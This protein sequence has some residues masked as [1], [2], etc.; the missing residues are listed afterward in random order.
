MLACSAA[1]FSGRARA[2]ACCAGAGAVT[3]GRLAIHEDALVG[4]QLKG[5]NAFGAFASDATYHGSP[6]NTSEW[7][8]E[9]DLFGALRVVPRGQLA[10]A[11][12]GSTPVTVS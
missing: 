12:P 1:A 8:L 4:L 10:L 5:A 9:Q 7:E 3:P 6:A 11:L 2:Q